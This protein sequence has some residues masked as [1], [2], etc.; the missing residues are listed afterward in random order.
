MVDE[1]VVENTDSVAN[2]VEQQVASESSPSIKDLLRVGLR[3][4][5]PANRIRIPIFDNELLAE[6][7]MTVFYNQH[8]YNWLKKHPSLPW[9]EMPWPD[10]EGL[11]TRVQIRAQAI[12]EVVARFH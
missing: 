9:D 6:A 3:E 4:F 11:E 8:C 10:V 5:D 1:A 2:L 12:R 7:R